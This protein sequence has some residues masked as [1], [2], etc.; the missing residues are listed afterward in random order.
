ME[1]A[2]NILFIEYL[3]E[4]L[5]PSERESFER[6]LNEDS[7]FS[8]EFEEFKAIYRIL[9]NQFSPERSA[10]LK[11]IQQADSNF[12]IPLDAKRQSKKIFPFKP[13]QMGVAASILLVIGLF[14]FNGVGKPTYSDYAPHEKIVLTLR[15]D[16]DAVS[17][18][19]E[20]AFNSE[21][22][23]EAVPYFDRLLELSPENAEIQYYKSIALVETDRFQEADSILKQLGSGNSAYAYKAIYLRALAKLK[24]KDYNDVEALLKTIPQNVPEHEKAQ[25][26]LSEL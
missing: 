15:S 20:S 7:A 22:Y 10:V 13:W 3:E 5:S 24:Q 23:K 11:S 8:A 12:A 9:E 26:L 25:K 4:S 14:I 1:Q 17:K 21:N 19:A 16:V 18:K 2:D 6:R